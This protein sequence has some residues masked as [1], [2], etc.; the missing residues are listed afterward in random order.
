[1]AHA[2]MLVLTAL[3]ASPDEGLSAALRA[4]FIAVRSRHSHLGTVGLGKTFSNWQAG[5]LGIA[6]VGCGTRLPR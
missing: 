5:D 6:F 1:M 2:V 3:T 4:G